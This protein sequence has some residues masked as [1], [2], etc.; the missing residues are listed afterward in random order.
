MNSLNPFSLEGKTILVTGASSGIGRVVAIECSKMGAHMVLTGRDKT[1]LEETR[2]RLIGD[3]HLCI[4]A[5][6]TDDS[7]LTELVD[8]CP[9][10]DGLVNNAGINYNIP[11]QFITREKITD[12]LSVN[13]IAPILLTKQL[14]KKKKLKQGCSIVFT[15]SIAGVY[16]AAIGNS[17]YASSKGAIYGF[18]R[19]AALELAPKCIRVNMVNPAVIDTEMTRSSVFDE[20]QIAK[21]M[22]L[23]PL[24]RHGRPEE[25]AY[26]MLYF[27]SDASSF[28]TGASLVIDGGFTLA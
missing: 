22:A 19:N 1:R 10:L 4:C 3:D 23:Y 28:T 27:L 18:V 2:L 8:K 9:Q 24:K 13:T 17:M 12:I 26:A 5:D 14:L 11:V 21:D 16:N 20:E 6:L 25:V 7:G 15:D